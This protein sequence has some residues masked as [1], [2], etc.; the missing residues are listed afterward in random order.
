[1]DEDREEIC[2]DAEIVNWTI[3]KKVVQCIVSWV[4][5]I[6]L[7]DIWLNCNQLENCT[8]KLY[9]F[10][11]KFLIKL[12]DKRD[13]WTLLNIY[14]SIYIDIVPLLPSNIVFFH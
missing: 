9:M 3:V 6:A 13:V 2:D 14:I 11:P 4:G 7:E 5:C 8:Q 10:Q 12:Q 1:M